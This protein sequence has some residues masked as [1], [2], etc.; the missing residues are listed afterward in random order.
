MALYTLKRHERIKKRRDYTLVYRHGITAE[1][2]HFKITVL[3]NSLGWS[4]IGIT[5]SRKIGTAVRRNMIK[6][7]IREYF[8]LHKAMLPHSHD[9]VVTAKQGACSLS[10][11]GTVG[12]LERVLLHTVFQHAGTSRA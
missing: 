1:S 3:P 2:P 11:A 8:R 4:R 6:R 9:I 12:E 10:Y 5:V 7:R